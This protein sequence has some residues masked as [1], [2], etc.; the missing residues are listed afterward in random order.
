VRAGSNPAASTILQYLKTTT[1]SHNMNAKETVNPDAPI[2][3]QVVEK[4]QE[5]VVF[6][7]IEAAVQKAKKDNAVLVFDYKKDPKA[8][9]S[10]IHKLRGL[11]GDIDRA[12]A[13]GKENILKAG[14]AIDAK[15][16]ELKADV[17]DM[18]EVHA[19]PLREAE[20][21]EEK[22]I[23]AH[24]AAIDAIKELGDDTADLNASQIAERIERLTAMP[25][26]AALEEYQ[27]EAQLQY[28]AALAKLNAALVARQKFDADQVELEELRRQKQ[29][30]IDAQR[31]EDERKQAVL[32]KIDQLRI[33][34]FAGDTP[35]AVQ[36]K[37]DMLKKR[38]PAAGQGYEEFLEAALRVYDEHLNGLVEALEQAEKRV[39]QE[40]EL[41]E[42]KRKLAEQERIAD[43]AQRQAAASAAE[44]KRKD[45]E[46]AREKAA[47][48]KREANKR[49]RNKVHKEIVD[50]IM[51]EVW[52]I[53]NPEVRAHAEQF[54]N[55]IASGKI[56]YV[57]I[58]Y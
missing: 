16:N 23:Q 54:I 35:S 37:I 50:A 24:Q 18:I 56:P 52:E 51:K 19:K 20:E 27:T 41:V 42:T 14:R 30:Q 34:A 40:L 58:S 21:R 1:G 36:T 26:T 10:H 28:N 47:A 3:G 49:H 22:R 55:A 38:M 32:R 13:V 17:A 45:D 31:H 39:Q 48:E 12:K 7:D 33:M 53:E 43:E 5:I 8:V 9:K 25:V 11:N 44:Q 15:A 57:F 6:N 46:A 4:L 2:E 29:A